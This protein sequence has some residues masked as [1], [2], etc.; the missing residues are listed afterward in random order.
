MV[1]QRFWSSAIYLA[2]SNSHASGIVGPRHDHMAIIH[3]QAIDKQ[4]NKQASVAWSTRP[5]VILALTEYVDPCSA[6][7]VHDDGS[8]L[9]L[10]LYPSPLHQKAPG[11][12]VSRLPNQGAI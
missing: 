5:E 1:T 8:G 11:E 7:V 6:K 4:A 9:V 10:I 2:T 12:P 3:R